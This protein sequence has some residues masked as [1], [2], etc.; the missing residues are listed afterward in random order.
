M[1]LYARVR[2]AVFVDGMSIRAAARRFGLHRKSVRKMLT[3]A[4]PPGYRE[5]G[6]R[7]R[8]KLGPFVGV[9]D[10]LLERDKAAPAKQR[11]TAKRIWER[12]RDEHG[13]GG[14]YTTV[15]DYVREHRERHREMFVPLA[16]PPG[17]AQ[18]DFG[19]ALAVIGGVER[20]VFFFVLDLPHSDAGFVKAY[21]A[22]TT[23][24]F[25]DGHNAAFALFGGVPRSILYD[26]TTLAVAEILAYIYRM[27]RGGARAARPDR[28]D[29]ED[30]RKRKA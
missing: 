30:H 9:I 25:C 27:M 12:L 17:D 22:E 18:A 16:H 10:E 13:Y 5:A 4:A 3:F 11:H 20:K 6:P 2:R 24:A 14:G 1:E 21:P 15:K 28:Q 19:E 7:R 26:N 23:E 29:G 8:P